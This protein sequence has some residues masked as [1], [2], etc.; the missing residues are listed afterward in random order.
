[1]W[2]MV[3]DKDVQISK[4][5]NNWDGCIRSLS[6]LTFKIFCLSLR[7]RRLIV[8]LI[9]QF[10]LKDRYISHYGQQAQQNYTDHFGSLC[11][12]LIDLHYFKY[13]KNLIK[14]LPKAWYKTDMVFLFLITKCITPKLGRVSYV[15]IIIWYYI[16]FALDQGR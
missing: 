8:D 4:I 10:K 16:V 5:K 7:M 13:I 12:I 14:L 6:I 1:M 9:W 2:T 15:C 3:L 11:L